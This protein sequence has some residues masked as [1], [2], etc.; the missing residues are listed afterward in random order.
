MK[1]LI[2]IIS[3][4]FIAAVYSSTNAQGTA[5]P[6]AGDKGLQD[7]NVKG[8]SVE[9]ERIKRDA[10][11]S[12]KSSKKKNEKMAQPETQPED[13]SELELKYPEI[14]ED[15]EQ[16]QMSYDSIIKAYAPDKTIDYKK[17]V[18]SSAEIKKRAERL[19][20][21]L[22][23]NSEAEKTDGEKE[24]KPENKD[25]EKTLRALI[26]DLDNAVGKFTASPI[27]QN[28]RT[29]DPAESAKAQTELENIMKFSD[30]IGKKTGEKL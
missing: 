13:R 22:F 26:V 18:E 29:P 2:T 21:N 28:L 15:F 14:K 24:E 6:G 9:L 12:D 8:R 4:I 27:F 30:L 11:K 17:I 1:K 7:R 23:P 20:A 19:K 10:E 3:I 5:P 25:A 16:L